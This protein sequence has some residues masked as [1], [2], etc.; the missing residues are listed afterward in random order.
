MVEVA[1][2]RLKIEAQAECLAEQS[3]EIERLRKEIAAMA[4]KKR[5]RGGAE[6]PVHLDEA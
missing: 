3:T 2:Y 1:S 6:P 5:K 4:A